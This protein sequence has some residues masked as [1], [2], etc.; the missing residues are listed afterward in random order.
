M[1]SPKHNDTMCISG[2]WLSSPYAQHHWDAH[3]LGYDTRL[4]GRKAEWVVRLPNYHTYPNFITILNSNLIQKIKGSVETIPVSLEPMQRSWLV[5]VPPS[6]ICM[7]TWACDMFIPYRPGEIVLHVCPMKNFLCLPC[8]M[9]ASAIKHRC[10]WG[11]RLYNTIR[12]PSYNLV[13][14][15]WTQG[16]IKRT[17]TWPSQE[18]LRDHTIHQ[19]LRKYL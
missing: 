14:C 2:C 4:C 11:R 7:D 3:M 19:C 15:V 6:I 13:C 10:T 9:V 17:C 18:S 12:A 8:Y 5:L 16:N 1:F